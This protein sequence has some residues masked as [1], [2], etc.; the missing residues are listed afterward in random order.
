MRLVKFLCAA[1]IAFSLSLAG[2]VGQAS[3]FTWVVYKTTSLPL[4][5]TY[6]HGGPVADVNA[7]GMTACSTGTW[8][9]FNAIY[10]GPGVVHGHSYTGTACLGQYILPSGDH[11]PS[12]YA[13]CKAQMSS[14]T[15]YANCL[16]GY[17]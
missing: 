5:T 16:E 15:Y 8:T 2:P 12:S 11:H 4:S 9:K 13:V 3:A 7:M 1:A 6:L 17:L 10:N 14:G